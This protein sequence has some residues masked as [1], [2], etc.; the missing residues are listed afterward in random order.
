VQAAYRRSYGHD[1]SEGEIEGYVRERFQELRDD[2]SMVV[3]GMARL[4][5]QV[6]ERFSPMHVQL[7]YPVGETVRLI[8]GEI[9]VV[10]FES[11]GLRLGLRGGLAFGDAAHVYMPLAPSLGM[12]LTTRDEGD[13]EMPPWTT[14]RMNSLIYRAADRF[15]ACH[16]SD[17]PAA[18]IGRDFVQWA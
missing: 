4:Y 12:M 3:Q 15:V 9:P 13:Q 2:Q 11:S 14:K 8:T 16:P 10:H 6:L 17:S 5:D 7:V 18:C 1:P